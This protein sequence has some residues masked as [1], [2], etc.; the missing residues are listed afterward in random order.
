MNVC[1]ASGRKDFLIV[2]QEDYFVDTD[3]AVVFVMVDGE[4]VIDLVF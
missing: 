3:D 4:V 1:N 2:L